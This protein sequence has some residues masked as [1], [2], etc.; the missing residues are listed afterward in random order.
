[1]QLFKEDNYTYIDQNIYILI[2][3]KYAL[4]T[5]NYLDEFKKNDN[6]RLFIYDFFYV[7]VV[8][9]ELGPTTG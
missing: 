8:R 4:I 3:K 5:M 1:M 9:K 6:N 2:R 7:Y